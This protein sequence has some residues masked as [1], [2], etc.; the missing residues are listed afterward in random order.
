MWLFLHDMKFLLLLSFSFVLSS[1]LS[2]A[3]N[4]FGP[5]AFRN[6]SPLVS[7]NDGTYQ[8]TARAQNVTG[9]FRFAYSGGSQT[10]D[11]AK[12]NWIFFING[13]IQKGTVQANLSDSN[14]DGVFD[15]ASSVSS[16]TNSTIS[17]PYIVINQNNNSSGTFSG[18]LQE[19][20]PNGTFTG[21]GFLQGL[22]NTNGEVF[23]I[24][25]GTTVT[26]TPPNTVSRTSVQ[27]GAVP[28][29]LA[30]G[31]IPKTTFSFRGVRTST[32]ATTATTATQAAN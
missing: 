25:E 28:F 1:T 12:N 27:V 14:L 13:Q 16:S 22:P 4:M 8:A 29:T 30:G 6:G 15:S 5:A 21:E 23:I 9:I 11:P 7:G 24:A 2:H 31:S 26:G 20:S 19:N 17:L 18:N 3:G 32:S 10:S